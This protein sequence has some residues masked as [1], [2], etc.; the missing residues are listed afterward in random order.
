MLWFIVGLYVTMEWL[1]AVGRGRR[2]RQ[3]RF[4]SLKMT[5]KPFVSVLIPAW[6]EKIV[7]RA[8]LMALRDSTYSNLQ[9][10]IIAGGPDGTEDYAR[11]ICA[12][13]PNYTVI[14]QP[15][16]GK[17]AALNLGLAQA[18]GE[19]IVVLDADTLVESSWL[20]QLIAPLT[21]EYAASTSNYFPL[22]QSW[23]SRYFELEKLSA[24][25]VHQD[26]T[27]NGC[28]G[29]A[30]RRDVLEQL[31]VFPENITVGV[32]WDLDQ[33]LQ[34]A[35]SRRIFNPEA[36]SKTA[37]PF[38]L[39]L[40]WRNQVR[41]RRA[42]L[43]TT[44]KYRTVS[45]YLFYGIALTFF[46][47]PFVVIGLN[48]IVPGVWQIW[49]LFWA[50]VLLRRLKLPIEVAASCGFG[51]MAWAWVPLILLPIDFMAGLIA[52]VTIRRKVIFFRGPRPGE[53]R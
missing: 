40:F 42:H 47:V 23:V 34:L 31:G 15:P 7:L 28:G 46:L 43:Q 9:V 49:P 19:I 4:P 51:W 22:V 20:E 37:L 25:L 24:Y 44:L 45:S 5:H 29:I 48:R 3:H 2:A 39:G 1:M 52:L 32:D 17:N 16:R 53:S 26:N 38:T 6:K 27:L 50:W 10:F 36:R 30:I 41:W 11:S 33:R 35:R 13:W 18:Q 12:P 14:S 8:T 21:Q